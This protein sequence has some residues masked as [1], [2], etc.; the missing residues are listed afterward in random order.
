MERIHREVA[1]PE[2]SLFVDYSEMVTQFGYVALW[3]T[4]WPLAPGKC[5]PASPPDPLANATSS[6]VAAEQLA[7]DAL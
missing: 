2:Y 5:F 3:S 1:L 7:R 6:D 4:I